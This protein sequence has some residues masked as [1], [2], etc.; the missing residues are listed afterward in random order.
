MLRPGTWRKLV[1]QR[2]L[3]AMCLPF[4][5]WVIIFSY[6]PLFGWLM[7]FKNY[8][9]AIG[10]LKSEWTGIQYFKEF[11]VDPRFYEIVRNTFVMGVLNVI[12]GTACAIVL[13]LMLNEVKTRF[14][15]RSI[16]TISYLPHFVSWV[17]VSNIFYT[18]LSTDGGVV[19][20]LLMWIGIID[21]PINW[22]AQGK[23][24]W[25]I[26]TIGQVWKEVGW[27]AIIYFAAITSIDK[28]LYEAGEVDGLGRIGKIRY[29][30]L[31]GIMPTIAILM[32]LNIGNLFNASGF[33]PSYLLGNNMTLT[34]SDN[35]AVYTYRYGLQ[36]SRF[37]MSAALGIFNSII[38]LILLFSANKLSGKFIEG[39]AI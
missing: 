37:S 22:M 4:V 10:V 7:A 32:V 31:P 35:L 21:D 20:N 25:V 13:A 6:T 28:T 29:I 23:L 8:K 11:L 5:A 36:M 14:F 27:T 26:V 17:I 1:R 19:N 12:F 39:K 2:Y 33:D 34:Y 30:T 16:Q 38:C 3:L 9:P 24:F 18:V 15:K